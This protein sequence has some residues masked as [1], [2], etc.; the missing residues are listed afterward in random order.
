MS[1]QTE[2]MHKQNSKIRSNDAEGGTNKEGKRVSGRLSVD[3]LC[4]GVRNLPVFIELCIS[5]L[6][7]G[8][9]V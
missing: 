5:P 2:S 9:P 1:F 3:V 7:Q 4:S 8:Q 6:P